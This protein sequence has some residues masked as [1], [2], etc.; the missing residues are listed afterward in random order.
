MA[1]LLPVADGP[2]GG[3][4]AG[5]GQA[6][7][8]AAG[9]GLGAV[10]LGVVGGAL[11][12]GL[13]AGL[14]AA[15]DD[16]VGAVLGGQVVLLKPPG[17]HPRGEQLDLLAAADPA[18]L[19]GLRRADRAGESLVQLEEHAGLRRG[20]PPG[21]H[22]RALLDGNL[23]APVAGG[24]MLVEADGAAAAGTALLLELPLPG[25]GDARPDSGQA[26]GDPGLGDHLDQP[27]A[28]ALLVLGLAAVE[29]LGEVLE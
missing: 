25:S 17:G 6:P 7:A 8:G 24:G 5:A 10:T 1:A 22:C 15:A 19:L 13:D 26:E 27:G 28:A 14:D 18:P 20:G 23:A 16:G 29:V 2:T 9:H 3:V 21:R 12:A 4:F 11:V